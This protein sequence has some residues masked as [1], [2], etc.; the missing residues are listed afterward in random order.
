MQ[1][2]DWLAA[3]GAEFEELPHEAAYSSQRL[4][5]AV[6]VRGDLV[7]KAVLLE[8]DDRFVVAVVPATHQIHLE[9]VRDAL[10]AHH[11]ELAGEHELAAHF[12]DCEW[13]ALLPF[14]SKYGLQTI[15]D[16]TLAEADEIVFEANDHRRAI[17]MSYRQFAEL[18]RPDVAVLSYHCC[19]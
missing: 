19:G 18:E 2:Q 13:G 9:M 5:Q 10:N 3:R 15:V 8:V 12:P 11:V 1:V 4:A 6:H 14:G 16:Y 7:A 17:R